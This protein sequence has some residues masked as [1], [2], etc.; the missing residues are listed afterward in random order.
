MFLCNKLKINNKDGT[1]KSIIF[2]K[3]S[4][5]TNKCNCVVFMIKILTPICLKFLIRT[6]DT[7]KR[8]Q[9]FVLN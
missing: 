5:T 3:L 9:S 6:L 7:S 4:E 1:H 8:L 2:V